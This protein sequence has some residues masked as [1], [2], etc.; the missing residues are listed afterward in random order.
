MTLVRNPR[1]REWSRDA[2]PAG[3]P[4][5]IEWRPFPNGLAALKAIERGQA[6]WMFDVA[7]PAALHR[8]ELA[9]PNQFHPGIYPYTGLFTLNVEKP[10][11][12]N[13]LARV[14]LNIGLDRR[15]L[16]NA[17]SSQGQQVISCQLSPPNVFGYAPICPDG[18]PPPDLA[19]A[20]E[21]V[22]RSGTGSMRVTVARPRTPVER[23]LFRTLSK[24]GYKPAWASPQAE[25]DV[26]SQPFLSD[27][28]SI[29][30]FLEFACQVVCDHTPGL[31]ALIRRA[32]AAELSSQ[33]GR[34]GPIWNAAER[35]YLRVGLGWVPFNNATAPG[36]VSA[37]VGNYQF[38]P[39]PGD[40]PLIDQMWVR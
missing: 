34:A 24:I 13:R 35:E 40:V 26:G 27:Y 7:P 28:P 18:P 16:L 8:A 39:P 4:D 31:Q 17:A 5:Q 20:R 15:S 3:Y 19:Q 38:A 23:E 1:F 25:A 22:A 9:H 32:Q 11:F 2:Q 12:Q 14:A 10:P 37:R 30:N 29:A 36:F 21:D 33:P 6:D